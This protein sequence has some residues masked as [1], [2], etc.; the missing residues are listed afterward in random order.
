MDFEHLT[1]SINKFHYVMHIYILYKPM[2][3]DSKI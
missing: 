3:M 1:Q 2:S